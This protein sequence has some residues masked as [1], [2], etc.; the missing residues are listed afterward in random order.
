MARV[1]AQLLAM[2]EMD[3]GAVRIRLARVTDVRGSATGFAARA[4][5]TNG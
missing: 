5:R 2:A 4:G 1:H 3:T